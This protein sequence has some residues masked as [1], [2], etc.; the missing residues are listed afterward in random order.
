MI[1]VASF[2]IMDLYLEDRCGV[3]E[4]DEARRFSLVDTRTHEREAHPL[5][6]GTV[7]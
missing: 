1:D 5:C 2:C 6:V 3:V 7:R 4:R